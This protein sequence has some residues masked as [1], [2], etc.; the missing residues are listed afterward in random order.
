ME[1]L[2][3]IKYAMCTLFDSNYL[4]K[5]LVLYD[6]LEKNASNF[7][8]YVLAMNDKCFDVLTDLNLKHLIPIKLSDFENE[9]LLKV[10]PTRGIGEYCWT[11]GSSLIKYVFETYS[12]DYCSYIDADMAFYDDPLML[13]QELESKNAS[14]S[15]VGHRFCTYD[16]KQMEWLVG[17]YCVE[18]NT[19]KN[20]SEA[21]NLLNLWI[22]QCIEH[23]ST[24]G[25]GIYWGDQ[26][27][28]DNWVKDY[29]FV[30]E[31]G[32]LGAGVAPWNIA[33]YKLVRV[34][35]DDIVIRRKNEEV[36]L[37]FYHF[38]NIEYQN[39]TSVNTKIYSFWNIDDKLFHCLY[40]NYLHHIETKKKKLSKEFGI[41]YI[42]RKH[43]GAN[44]K[45][46]S[47]IEKMLNMIKI[48]YWKNIIFHSIPRKLYFDKSYIDLD[49]I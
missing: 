35:G 4:D 8:L 38:E 47:T 25:D 11:C 18:C 7:T 22:S 5:G 10:K 21:L 28:L 49:N 1:D 20:N 23:C 30:I 41:D 2:K 46:E 40:D 26:K 17:K 29:D 44:N 36:K 19:F 34:N 39:R 6:S 37:L 33:Q 3:N 13:I 43:P 14:V 45:S 42:I 31:T 48:S 12:P 32:N 24:D 15:I 16:A 27:Y 9:E